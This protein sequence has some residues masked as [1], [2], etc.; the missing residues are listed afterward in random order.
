MTNAICL[1]KVQFSI[2]DIEQINRR[3][4]DIVIIGENIRVL[5]RV[6]STAIKERDSEVIQ[7]LA[8]AQAEAGADYIDLNVGPMRKN[9]EENMQWLVSTVQE[10]IDLPLSIDTINPVAMEARIKPC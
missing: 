3:V 7:N 8:R 9:P 2:Q 4:L 5:A 1:A 6:I 10:V